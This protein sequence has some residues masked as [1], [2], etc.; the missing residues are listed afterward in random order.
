MDEL[1]QALEVLRRAVDEPD[2]EK[3]VADLLESARLAL[4]KWKLRKALYEPLHPKQS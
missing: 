1:K 4:T 3:S 2:A